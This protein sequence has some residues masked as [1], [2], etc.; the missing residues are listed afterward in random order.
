MTAPLEPAAVLTVRGVSKAFGG[1]AALTGVDL[2]VHAGRILGLA[3]ANGAGKSTLINILTGQLPPD[4]GELRV[5]GEPVSFSS[6]REAQRHG[7][8]VVRQELDL[9]PDLT[10]AE[11]LFLGD[12]RPFQRALQL[13]RRQMREAA[14][15]LLRRMGLENDVDEL[16]RDVSIGDRQLV[17]AARALRSAGSVLLLDEP[18]SSLTPFEEARLFRVMRSLSDEG[19]GVVFISHR[20]DE[21]VQLCDSIVVL[22]DGRVAGEFAAT[23]DVLPQVVDAMVPGSAAVVRGDRAPSLG[24]PAFV[25]GAMV[26]KGRPPVDLAIRRGEVL[27]VFGL[28][29]AGKSSIGRSIAGLETLQSGSMQLAGRPYSPR[30]AAAGFARGVA[31]L[32][33][34]RR[35]EGIL[36]HLSVRQNM[37]V[38]A[39]RDVARGGVFDRRAVTALIREMTSRLRI[40]AASD[41]L[42]IRSLSGGN[43]QKVLVGRL[44]AEDLSLLV[45]DEPTHGIDVRA[46]ADLIDTVWDL[47][48]KGVAVLLISS[49]IAELRAACDRIIVVRNGAVVRELPA[50]T[51]TEGELMSAATG[52]VS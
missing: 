52:G 13:D 12:E 38:R 24:E 17:A 46:K 50:T 18:T 8:G 31:Y 1:V 42:D 41:A 26:I 45:L 21:V 47:T 48:G 2:S 3:G 28:V 10:I 40:K 32:S 23:V 27:G 5:S 19:V 43:Q 36:P 51:A 9:V 6:P 15:A 25:G 16:V 34:D 30:S 49:E 4:T 7:I 29:G 20:L 35:T 11:N 44:L 22:R 37:I 33:E 14:R 39:P